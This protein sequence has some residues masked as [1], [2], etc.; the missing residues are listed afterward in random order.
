MSDLKNDNQDEEMQPESIERVWLFDKVNEKGE[1]IETVEVPESDLSPDQH[2]A[3]A[4]GLWIDF[5]K[6]P[7]LAKEIFASNIIGEAMR[8]HESIAQD[9]M[10]KE[11]G[12]IIL[13]PGFGN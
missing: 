13:P 3:L 1:L 2:N 9:A 12:R 11:Q 5:M 10:T 8:G 7:E 6:L 4:K